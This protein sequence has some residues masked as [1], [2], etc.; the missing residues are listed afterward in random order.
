MALIHPGP[1]LLPAGVIGN[2]QMRTVV[3]VG[4]LQFG[5]LHLLG[6]SDHLWNWEEGQESQNQNKRLHNKKSLDSP[7]YQDTTSTQMDPGYQ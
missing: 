5:R 2:Q 4:H 3:P 6:S 1:D 7:H